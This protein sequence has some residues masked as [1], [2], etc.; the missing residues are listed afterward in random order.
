MLMG[1]KPYLWKTA[2]AGALGVGIWAPWAHASTWSGRPGLGKKMSRRRSLRR[3][4]MRS[5][6][7]SGRGRAGAGEEDGEDEDEEEKK[8][9]GEDVCNRVA[10]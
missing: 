2:N 7:R 1:T 10:V 4:G 3:G 6:A 5:R 9:E 8:E